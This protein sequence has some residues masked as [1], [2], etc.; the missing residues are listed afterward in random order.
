MTFEKPFQLRMQVSSKS[1][2]HVLVYSNVCIVLLLGKTSLVLL[3][4]VLSDDVAC[5][6]VPSM[7]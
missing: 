2:G 6:K 3:Q 5:C 4:R 7:M 1:F